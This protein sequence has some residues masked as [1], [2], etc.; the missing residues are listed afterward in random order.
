[1]FTNN[2]VILSFR[3]FSKIL[4]GDCFNKGVLKPFIVIPVPE[5]QVHTFALGG[6]RFGSSRLEDGRSSR[7][8]R[9]P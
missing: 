7:R 5:H 9:Y 3:S 4:V 1:M 6:S 8:L 2:L